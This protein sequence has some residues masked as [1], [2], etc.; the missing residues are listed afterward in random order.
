MFDL[1]AFV[2]RVYPEI[3]PSLWDIVPDVARDVFTSEVLRAT[4]P[5]FK[6]YPFY[7]GG[8]RQTEEELKRDGQLR[9]TRVKTWAAEIW[10]FLE[11]EGRGAVVRGG[12][13]V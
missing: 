12:E 2:D 3:I 9:T 4:L 11:G 10:R 1:F 8:Y 6:W 5:G 7:I 13:T